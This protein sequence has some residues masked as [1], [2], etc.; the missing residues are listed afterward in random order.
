[1]QPEATQM[2]SNLQTLTSGFE[3]EPAWEKNV[4][5]EQIWLVAI[6]TWSTLDSEVVF[7]SWVVEKDGVVSNA[8]FEPTKMRLVTRTRD[9]VLKHKKEFLLRFTDA[10]RVDVHGGGD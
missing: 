6:Q 8:V 5:K 4:Q 10:R 3:A 1:M 9:L 2:E 7:A